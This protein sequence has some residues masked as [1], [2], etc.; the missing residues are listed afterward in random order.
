MDVHPLLKKNCENLLEQY[1]ANLRDIQALQQTLIKDILPDVVDE[2]DL[3]EEEAEWARLWLSDTLSIFHIFRRNDFTKPFALEAIRKTLIWRLNHLWPPEFSNETR[4]RMAESVR[5]LPQDVSDPFGR[6]ILVIQCKAFDAKSEYKSIVY[7]AFELLRAHLYAVNG[8]D[9]ESPAMQYVVLLDLKNL[10]MKAITFDM[11]SWVLTDV[12]PKFPGL[13][14]A[15]FMINYHW[16]HAGL[17]GLLKHVLPSSALSRVVF[18][19]P[20]DLIAFFSP[21][22][23]PSD[24]GGRLE[25][26]SQLPDPLQ[27]G[28]LDGTFS[29][30]VRSPQLDRPPR[31]ELGPVASTESLL[32]LSPMSQYNPF[33]G[34]PLAVLGSS[35]SL[36]HG[37]RR[38]RDLART[39][40]HLFWIRWGKVL[41]RVFWVCVLVWSA[42]VWVQRRYG[43]SR[44]GLVYLIRAFTDVVHL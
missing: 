4:A 1:Q 38:K 39:L 30:R 24:Y 3:G 36:N 43:G 28:Q 2:L 42:R 40:A 16:T 33:Y 22:S 18:P 27:E 44:K 11:V 15:V 25:P 32:A 26:I 7:H 34:Y 29:P 23:L 19:S 13:L 41:S 9:A 35:A 17:W 12:I 10:S 37:R 6:P 5:C 8:Q 20:K 21:S 31:T 14:S